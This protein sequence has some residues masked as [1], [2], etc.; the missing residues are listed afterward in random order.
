MREIFRR[1]YRL[2]LPEEVIEETYERT[3]RFIESSRIMEVDVEES[4]EELPG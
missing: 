3:I 4:P 2:E 1:V